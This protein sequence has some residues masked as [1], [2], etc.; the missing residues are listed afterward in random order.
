MTTNQHNQHNPNYPYTPYLQ[1]VLL[2]STIL[3]L[4]FALFFRV[5]AVALNGATLRNLHRCPANPVARD[6]PVR[7]YRN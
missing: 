6:A 5:L 3:F 7:R 1:A 2:V 4:L